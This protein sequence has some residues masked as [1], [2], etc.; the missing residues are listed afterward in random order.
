[1]QTYASMLIEQ[2]ILGGSIINI[3]SIV[4]KHGNIGQ[5]NYS[6]SKAGVELLIKTAVKEFGKYGIRCNAILPGFI[7]SPMTEAVPEK[8]LQKIVP[9]IPLGRLGEPSGTGKNL[10]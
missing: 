10:F 4:G 1:M 7:K 6:A 5:S 9:M 2:Q 3:G 8:V